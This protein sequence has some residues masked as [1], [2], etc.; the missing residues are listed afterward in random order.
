MKSSVV[1]AAG[2][3]YNFVTDEKTYEMKL[4][5][6]LG[7]GENSLGARLL[8]KLPSTMLEGI[9]SEAVGGLVDPNTAETW[10]SKQIGKISGKN[11]GIINSTYAQSAV[12]EVIKGIG[13]STAGVLSYV[14]N[15]QDASKFW[16]ELLKANAQGAITSALTGY[17]GHKHRADNLAT[18][19]MEHGELKL[20]NIVADY[21][22]LDQ[23]E[24]GILFNRVKNDPVIV[25]QMRNDPTGFFSQQLAAHD[26]ANAPTTTPTTTPPPDTTPPPTDVDS[27]KKKPTDDV[28]SSDDVDA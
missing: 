3:T 7:F 21:P 28:D 14:D 23:K 25:E 24:R 19:L 2:E 1:A 17:Y 8:K 5:E 16:K 26:A 13:G 20:D 27:S 15:Y 18:E 10:L 9:A 4:G 6:A 22:F 12:V 11:L